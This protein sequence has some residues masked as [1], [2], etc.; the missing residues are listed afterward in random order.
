MKKRKIDYNQVG[1]IYKK[2]R[3]KSTYIIILHTK[4]EFNSFCKLVEKKEV[5]LTFVFD[6][7]ILKDILSRF[8]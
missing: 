2:K 4:R 3:D 6:K 5:K 7:S 1:F 8:D